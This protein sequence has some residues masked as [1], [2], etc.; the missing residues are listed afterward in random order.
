M[1]ERK[2]QARDGIE[3]FVNQGGTISI[4]QDNMLDDEEIVIVHPDD[5]DRLIEFLRD[6]KEEARNTALEAETQ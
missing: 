1:A 3:V 2:I 6:A 4:K 5:V